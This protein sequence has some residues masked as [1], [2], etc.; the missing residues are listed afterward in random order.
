MA[1]S[2]ASPAVGGSGQSSPSG[3]SGGR[4]PT[5][6]KVLL[7]VVLP[8]VTVL[9]LVGAG[10][11]MSSLFRGTAF[12]EDYSADAGSQVTVTVP[13][14]RLSFVPS[15]NDHVHAE[16]RGSYSGTEPRITV[17][18]SGDETIIDGGCAWQWFSHCSLTFE[19]SLPASADL[20]V[21]SSNGRVTATDLDGLVD[22]RT[23][24]GALVVT[25][26][27]G[28]LRLVTTN[29]SIDVR[30]ASSLE[31]SARTTNGRVELGF[32]DP[33]TSVE[34]RSTNGAITIRVPDDNASYFVDARTTNGGI[35]TDEVPSNRQ[36]DRTI[37]A[38]TTNGGVTVERPRD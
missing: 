9:A 5:G 29:G 35:D 20:S 3:Q 37:S 21:T 38:E 31:V 32:A 10:V 36:A 15:E 7:F 25:D 22:I 8:I 28:D 26:A 12:A 19:V 17:R 6:V 11:I 34:A 30:E 14:A 33:P 23:T 1:A 24:N 13:N 4:I 2:P 27:S 18:T 16:V